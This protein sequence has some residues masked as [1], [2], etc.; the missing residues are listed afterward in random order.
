MFVKHIVQIV[1][2]A[3]FPVTQQIDDFGYYLV[4]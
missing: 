1:G 3:H 4:V 2:D